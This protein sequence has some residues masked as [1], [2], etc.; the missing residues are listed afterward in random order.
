MLSRRDFLK[1]GATLSALAF[2]FSP[3]KYL[4]AD[5]RNWAELRGLLSGTGAELCFPGENNYSSYKKLF[6]LRLTPAP[7]AIL[8]G[9]SEVAIQR[10]IEWCSTNDIPVHCRSGGHSYEGLSSGSGLVVDMRPFQKLNIDTANNRAQ[11]GAGHLL[12]S[13][14]EKLFRNGY[15]IP[16][17]SCATVGLSG[18]TLGGGVGLSARQ[19]GLTCDQV[20]SFKVILADGK[21][22][23]ASSQENPDLYWALRGGGGGQFGI[24]TEFDFSLKRAYEVYTFV[25]KWPRSQYKEVLENWQQQIQTGS[26]QV[27]SIFKLVGN[28]NGMGDVKIVGQVL[29]RDNLRAPTEQEAREL[30]R[31]YVVG[32]PSQTNLQRRTFLDAANYF[33]GGEDPPVKFKAKSSYAYKALDRDAMSA[34]QSELDNIPSGST[35]ALMFDSDG[36]AVADKSSEDTAF[37]HR[38]ALYSVQYYTQWGGATSSSQQLNLMNRIYQN[39]N[40]HFSGYCYYN[41]CDADL[42]RPLSRY[43]G[44]NVQRL[45]EIK[46]TYDPNGLFQNAIQNFSSR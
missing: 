3:F 36:G 22:V 2:A 27:T 12:G 34:I 23:T 33:A 21:L 42:D 6:N 30:I 32:R 8:R 35:V 13:L 37:F 45:K 44:D 25:L 10:A 41:Y 31:P 24:V 9:S 26:K 19:W 29:S 46:D 39:I 43:F 18:L 15:A 14:I 20:N 7:A 38:K 5:A 16:T 1:Q 28:A 11:I 17:G 40:P 4:W